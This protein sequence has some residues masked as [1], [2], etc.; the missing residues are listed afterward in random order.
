MRPEKSQIAMSALN[1]FLK[2]CA[3]FADGIA[4]PPRLPCPDREDLDRNEQRAT[5]PDDQRVVRPM[6]NARDDENRAPPPSG[7]YPAVWPR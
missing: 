3:M 2:F 5:P 4:G 6:Q 1:H 7:H